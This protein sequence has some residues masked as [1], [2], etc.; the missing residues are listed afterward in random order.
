LNQLFSNLVNNALKYRDPDRPLSISITSRRE[1]DRNVY[2]V[3]DTGVGIASEHQK[4][5]F[6]IFHRLNPED[7]QGE[8]LGLTIVNKIVGRHNG[9]IWVESEV[10]KGSQF[11]I[12]LHPPKPNVEKPKKAK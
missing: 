2:C 5:V 4:K 8:G 11:Y 12:A 10:G 1:G 7:S 9:K 3:S 6:E